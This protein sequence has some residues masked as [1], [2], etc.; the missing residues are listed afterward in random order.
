M[1]FS[2]L[3][4]FFLLA[5]F[6]LSY[7][8]I[9][10]HILNPWAKD[11]ARANSPVYIQSSE[12]G[13]Y[14]GT[15]MT[16]D[17]GNWLTYTFK[18]TTP[19][20]NDRFQLMSAYPTINDN[21]LNYPTGTSQ[22][23][24]KDLFAGHESATDIWLLVTDP[25]KAPQIQFTSPPYKVFRF[26]K[27]W[28]MGGSYMEIKNGGSF[29]LK[30]LGDYCGWL[31]LKQFTDSTRFLVKFRNS[32]DT[33]MLYT[34]SGLGNGDYIDLSSVSTIN[35]TVWIL[36]STAGPPSVT[37]AFPGKLGDCSPAILGSTLRDISDSTHPDFNKGICS[38][39]QGNVG[40]PV[41]GLV[42]KRLGSDG[43]PVKS[44]TAPCQFNTNPSDWFKAET[45]KTIN[46]TS[47]TNEKC[48]NLILHKNDEGLYVYDTTEF[49]PLDSFQY[50]D[51]NKSILNQN[52]ILRFGHNYSFTMELGAEF[53]YVKGQQF[54]FRGDDDVW[55]YIDSQL[56]VDLGGIHYPIEGSVDLDTL[57]LTPGKTYSFKL[58][59]CE[60]NCCGSSFKMVTSINL[61]TKSMLFH[62]D[63][64]LAQGRTQYDMYEN[65]TKESK[66]CD[67]SGTITGIAKAS[68]E[69]WLEGPPPYDTPYRL[70]SDKTVFGGLTVLADTSIIIDEP[71]ITDLPV[72]NYIV[73]YYSTKDRS[74][75]GT[76]T[77]TVTEQP[78]ISNPVKT[79]AY[80]SDGY[81]SVNRAEI[82]FTD[83][84]TVIPDSMLLCWP[85]VSNSKLV[86]K[87]GITI[88]PL[89]KKH[90]TV[91]LTDP[92]P[93]EITT[94]SGTARL[95]TC[96][97]YDS[98]YKSR[99][100]L[101]VPFSLADSA[102]PLIKSAVLK[103]RIEPGNDTILCTFTEKLADTALIGKSLVLYKNG[104]KI[105]MNT[106]NTFPL[107]DTIVFVI[108]DLKEN[109]PGKLDSVAINPSGPVRD[110]YKNP[111]HA[112]NR[113]VPFI[114]QR[115][116]PK[117][118]GAYY[119]D[120]DADGI[121]DAA[122][123]RFN[124]PVYKG[125]LKTSFAWA[126]TIK[127][128]ALD[129]TRFSYGK[130]SSEIIVKLSGAFPKDSIMT[131]GK[132]TTNVVF[133]GNNNG[134]TIPVADSA[135]PVLTSAVIILGDPVD[136]T[137][138]KDTLVCTFSE[139]V[140]KIDCTVPFL[141]SNV[142]SG[143]STK[144][145]MSLI[146]TNHSGNKWTFVVNSYNGIG[147][148]ANGD[149]AWINDTCGLSDSLS[150]RQINPNN[151]R[152]L[153][154]LRRTPPKLVNA[155]YL[156]SDADGIIDK[157]IVRFNKT[158]YKGELKTTFAWASTIKTRDLDSTSFN[159]GKD[160]SEIMINLSGA[161]SQKLSIMTSGELYV[162]VVSTENSSGQT[163]PVADSAAPVLTSAEIIPGKLVD[164]I[165]MKDTLICTY[166]EA[167]DNISC[168]TPF[169]FSNVSSGRYIKYQMSLTSIDHSIFVINSID[170]IGYPAKGDSV[171]IN[172]TCGL[173]D[174]LSNK[175]FNSNN[176]RVL[177]KVNTIPVSY[178]IRLGPN[179]VN[180]SEEK[181][182][183]IEIA[184]YPKLRQLKFTVDLSIYD[185]VGNVVFKKQLNSNDSPS[186][187]VT[188]RWP[189]RNRN[190]RIVGSGTYLAIIK[191][192]DQG[193]PQKPVKKS[194]GV[195]R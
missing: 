17:G 7:S 82:Y 193:I 64:V 27:P 61:R 187:T 37:S 172:D 194:I 24:F 115:T 153:L 162:N 60:R 147:H 57:H 95:G 66:A 74:M 130:D 192:N 184:P 140:D 8:D 23:V 179:P 137:E 175:Q 105:I 117:L 108:E 30:G 12:S 114:L 67:G 89:D 142:S 51:D 80:F 70:P 149:S 35:D 52:G 88:D 19:T 169:L 178:N 156:D 72:G 76:F 98:T 46:N 99:P 189:G 164:G 90:I 4:L 119:L 161:F 180:L 77:F 122:I 139:I 86:K 42:Q 6:S 134:Q 123:V 85:S 186:M 14:P 54:Y 5:A 38:G 65:I 59:Y 78:R 120:S 43:K 154:N 21:R 191:I 97:F 177:L 20:T 110:A 16:L 109:S 127:T 33:T 128:S 133:S 182:V 165:Q 163:M 34:A 53:K 143:R 158:V 101:T 1:Y 157:A 75:E 94:L 32:L 111:A 160:S 148:P 112:S 107:G 18:N 81:G 11:S 126:N 171:W 96:Y 25:S 63:S 151:H 83:T 44:N 28:E 116:P 26:F 170:G 150:N 118:I 145:Q 100:L 181:E 106:L 136:G 113:P 183:L 195:I 50:L 47:Y 190:G 125:E 36:G 167:I 138:T 2:R 103:E 102:G 29:R 10:I 39:N 48:Y 135:A 129:S 68:V 166:S 173:S 41:L 185:Q 9:T 174:L 71:S 22:L 155:Y 121:I 131:S 152:V 84:L 93:R 168:Q 62:K 49:Y 132:M 58:F 188:F 56:V 40:Y 31:T 92:F 79:A 45:L 15:Q 91:R 141:F 69:F 104:N 144:Y 87:A 124:K 3:T 55:V 146:S 13:W 73:H 159:Y 176:H